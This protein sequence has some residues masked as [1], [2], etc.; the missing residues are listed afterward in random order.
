MTED[1]AGHVRLLSGLLRSGNP[2]FRETLLSTLRYIRDVLYDPQSH[3]FAGS[4]D[5]DEAYYALPLEERRPRQAPYVDRTSYTN[6][7]AALAGALTVAGSELSV[8]YHP[9]GNT[10]A[11]RGRPRLRSNINSSPS[12]L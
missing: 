5:A 3:F 7:T 6:W 8:Q 1:H 9:L 4:Q 10:T 2:E 11:F 12:S